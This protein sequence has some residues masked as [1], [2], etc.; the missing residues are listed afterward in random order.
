VKREFVV[1]R[2]SVIIVRY[3][4]RSE[5]DTRAKAEAVATGEAHEV[6]E[7]LATFKVGVIE[8]RVQLQPEP[9]AVISSGYFGDKS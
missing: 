3:A 7:T 1:V 6:M 2:G 5:A 9:R 8:D 4:V